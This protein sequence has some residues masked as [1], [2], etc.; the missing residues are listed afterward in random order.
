LKSY[1]FLDI[2]LFA[3]VFCRM[4]KRT[5]WV[6]FVPDGLI[7]FYVLEAEVADNWPLRHLNQ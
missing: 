2:L 3:V 1:K 5:V 6:S 7:S 4:H